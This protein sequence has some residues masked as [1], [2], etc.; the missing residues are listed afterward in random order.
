M[1]SVSNKLHRGRNLCVTDALSHMV[2]TATFTRLL[3]KT[4]SKLIGMICYY[5][6]RMNE[7]SLN[8][9]KS[10]DF[11]TFTCILLKIL[12][13]VVKVPFVNRG[14]ICYILRF[15]FSEIHRRHCGSLSEA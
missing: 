13:N 1:Q 10:H 3:N 4:S 11:N 12:Q 14:P 8:D 9:S 5:A 2:A 15:F 6:S 7:P